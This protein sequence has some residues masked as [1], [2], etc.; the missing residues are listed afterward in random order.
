L[1]RN[2]VSPWNKIRFCQEE[3][4]PFPAPWPTV[5]RLLPL[6]EPLGPGGEERSSTAAA[7]KTNYKREKKKKGRQESLSLKKIRKGKNLISESARIRYLVMCHQPCS[8]RWSMSSSRCA[9]SIIV[10]LFS[11][12]FSPFCLPAAPQARDN[13]VPHGTSITARS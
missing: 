11:G 12:G 9:Y 1:Q 13:Q 6:P 7:Q 4:F 2:V 8:V 5:R 3:A 10:G